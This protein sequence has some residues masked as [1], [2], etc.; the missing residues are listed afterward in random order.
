MLLYS[1]HIIAQPTNFSLKGIAAVKDGDAYPYQLSLHLSGSSLTGYSV[2]KQPDGTELKAKIKGRI[3][4]RTQLLSFTETESIGE[5]PQ[6][7][8]VTCLFE[9]RLF[10][11][12]TDGKFYVTGIFTGKDNL[13]KPCGTGIM[14]FQQPDN[15]SSLFHEE[16]VKKSVTISPP[17]VK[18]SIANEP[19]VD[20]NTITSGAD[21]R[22]KWHSE[23]CVVQVWDGGIV[24]GDVITL[25]V[26][27]KEVLTDYTLTKEKKEISFPF[28]GDT[29]I[30]T[31]MAGDE[32]I[33]PPNTAQMTLIDGSEEHKIT[34]FNKKGKTASVVLIRK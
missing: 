30:I 25:S 18:D 33:A 22:I 3:N 27:N 10:Y 19:V 34:A 29:M 6:E 7:F 15:K 23:K 14:T 28:S 17:V 21:K 2:T 1:T 5:I 12:L 9:A 16:P 13:G 20:N 11:K 24:D 4:K 8:N 26:N 31:I 32:G